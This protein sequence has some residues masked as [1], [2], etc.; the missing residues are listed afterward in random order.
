[1]RGLYGTLLVN[2]CKAVVKRI[3]HRGIVAVDLLWRYERGLIRGRG[4]WGG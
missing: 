1:M 3:I 2:F 4:R